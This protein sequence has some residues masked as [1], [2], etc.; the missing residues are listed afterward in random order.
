[1]RFYTLEQEQSERPAK[2]VP[3]FPLVRF[4]LAALA[5]AVADLNGDGI[6]DMAVVNYSSSDVSV[7][8]GKGDGTF[9]SAVNYAAG[10]APLTAKD[11]NG[12][13]IPDLAVVSE[14]GVRVL[15]GNGDGTFQTSPI[16]YVAGGRLWLRCGK[17]L[18]W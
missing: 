17:R 5:L 15:L 8:L 6:L 9:Q 12:D 13:G 10:A 14:A 1:M 11:F 2:S 18:Q 3:P 16:T 4:A 7:L